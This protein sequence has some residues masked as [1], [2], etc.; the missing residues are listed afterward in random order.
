MSICAVFCGAESWDD[1]VVFT[2]SRKDWDYLIKA[3]ETVN[4]TVDTLGA[5]TLLP[6]AKSETIECKLND[7]Q[8]VYNSK[9]KDLSA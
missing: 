9:I 4:I 2:E 1:M 3:D 7:A 6:L 5:L 8:P